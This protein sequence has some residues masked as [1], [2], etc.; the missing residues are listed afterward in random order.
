MAVNPENMLAAVV[1][2]DKKPVAF[3]SNEYGAAKAKVFWRIGGLR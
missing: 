1:W 2:M 3:L